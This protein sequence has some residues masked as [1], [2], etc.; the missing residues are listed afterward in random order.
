MRFTGILLLI[1]VVA[2]AWGQV[3]YLEQGWSPAQR[4]DFY[5]TA[6]GSQLI[7]F[8]WFLVLEQPRSEKL[9]RDADNIRKYGF[10]PAEPSERNPH[11]LPIG[12]VLDGIDESSPA[13]ELESA[14]VEV[15]ESSTRFDVKKAYLGED[16]DEKLYPQE[17][18]AWFGLTCAACHTHEL[19]YAGTTLRIDGGSSQ[20]D[21]ESFLRDL[22][23]ALDATWKSPGKLV[24]FAKGVGRSPSHIGPFKTEVRQIA[25]AVNRLVERSQADHPEGDYGYARLDAFGAILNAVCETA[26]GEPDNHREANAPVSYPS[27]WNTPQMSYVQWNASA[28][29]PEGRNVGEVLGVFGTYT[30]APGPTQFDSTVRLA[31]LIKLE[32]ELVAGLHAPDWPEQ[33]LGELDADKVARGKALFAKNCVS[34]HAIRGPNGEFALNDQGRIPVRSSKAQDVKTDPQF[35]RNF[36]ETAKTGKLASLLGP[37]DVP[38]PV[39]LVK[40]VEEIIKNRARAERVRPPTPPRGQTLEPAGPGAGYISRPLEGIWASPPYFHNGSVPNLYETLLPEDERSQTFWVG[41]RQFDPKKVGFVTHQTKIG[42]E[43]RVLD[44]A[45]QPIPGNHN[46]GHSGHGAKPNEGFTQTFENG[47]WRDFTEADRYDLVEYMKSLSSR[48]TPADPTASV[49]EESRVESIPEG[50]AEGIADIVKLTAQRMQM[51][52]KAARV[53]RGV[54]PK[55]HGCVT[56]KFE[57]RSDLPAEYTVGVFQ[58][59]ASYDA[60]IRFSNADVAVRADSPENSETGN[61]EHGSRGMAIKLMGVKGESLLPLHGA[62]TQDFVMINQPA[63]AFAN[64]EDYRLL[65]QVLV[66][67]FGEPS[68][69]AHFFQS[70]LNP[71]T[72]TAEQRQRAQ[73]TFEIVQRIKANMV[74]GDTGAFFAPPASPADNPYFSASPF[75]FGKGRVMRFQAEPVARSNDPPNVSDPDYLRN[76]LIERL[77][78]EEIVFDFSIQVRKAEELDLETD[79]EN[80]STEWQGDY[81]RVAR[82]TIP[83]QTFDSPEQR[84]RCERLFFTPWHGITEHRPLGGINRLRKAVYLGSG[85]HRNLPKEPAS[86]ED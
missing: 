76:A 37:H 27:L 79:V 56:A 38:R 69:A 80:A 13:A 35:L 66:D 21:I 65:S 86:L 82:I 17:K 36:A 61:R 54:H 59:G 26:L 39:M 55:D 47:V 8:K 22:G 4:A 68:P 1:A 46:G 60:F 73:R 19:E 64:V 32:H 25:Q 62:L 45:G 72:S 30:I 53:L 10:L 81:E 16:F 34:C 14:I 77:A 20:A 48:P 28:E 11:G 71:A 15:I 41:T 9:F 51:Q 83:A 74:N 6:Q 42:S 70:R 43:F 29:N 49:G 12:F 23:A 44:S 57:V 18:E 58:P 63:F 50:E 52:Y 7:P 33:I 40:V 24:R 5:N 85:K 67:H 2:P 78:N 3:T 75:L 84:E 31:N